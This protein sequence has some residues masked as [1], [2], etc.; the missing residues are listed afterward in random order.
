MQPLFHFTTLS[1]IHERALQPHN[2]VETIA[3]GN[4]GV[5]ANNHASVFTAQTYFSV[6][7][8][9]LQFQ[10]A[11]QCL[12]LGGIGVH[13]PEIMALQFFLAAVAEHADKRG[14]RIEHLTCW[15]RKENTFPQRFKKLSKANLR[16]VLRG[17]VSRPPT[18]GCDLP[19]GLDCLKAAVEKAELSVLLQAHG[20]PSRPRARL[21][22]LCE[23]PFSLRSRGLGNKLIEGVA[24][25]FLERNPKNLCH[26]TV[27]DLQGSAGRQREN[28]VIQIVNQFPV[29]LLR[30]GNDLKK[31][32]KLRFGGRRGSSFVQI[33]QQRPQASQFA[34]L[35][36]NIDAKQTDENHKPNGQSGGTRWNRS[37]RGPGC[38]RES[39]REGQKQKQTIA[40][41][42][43]LRPL[44]PLPFVGGTFRGIFRR[45]VRHGCALI[46]LHG[47][48]GL[49]CRTLLMKF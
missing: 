17:N 8:R 44:Q 9:A 36:P 23:R 49:R 2:A 32:F 48:S 30:A 34:V 46:P 12:A 14:I 15:R 31:L 25:Q 24:N 3:D 11:D 33:A 20:D 19:A 27:G 28:G 13:F 35:V 10:F 40:P 18:D 22:K 7:N 43:A 6:L 45:L 29:A 39:D 47:R 5:E 26:V 21:E 37:G 42:R 16:F 41:Q 38:Q 4:P 1:N